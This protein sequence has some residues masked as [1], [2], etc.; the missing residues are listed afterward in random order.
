MPHP[1]AANRTHTLMSIVSCAVQEPLV[2]GWQHPVR[3]VSALSALPSSYFSI[4]SQSGLYQVVQDC[5]AVRTEVTCY[6]A[7]RTLFTSPAYRGIHS[8][9]C[10]QVVGLTQKG[11]DTEMQHFSVLKICSSVRW[12][13]MGLVLISLCYGS[14]QLLTVQII[15]RQCRESKND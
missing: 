1:G 2:S 12:S 14:G 13:F 15:F 6:Q 9:T 3:H 4:S 7:G 8:H 5:K 10:V 11:L